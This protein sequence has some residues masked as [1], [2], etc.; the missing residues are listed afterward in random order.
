M[1]ASHFFHTRIH[2]VSLYNPFTSFNK[3]YHSVLLR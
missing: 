2:Q 3:T 1:I